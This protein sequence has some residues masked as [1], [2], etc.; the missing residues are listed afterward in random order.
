[1]CCLVS[2][3]PVSVVA[4]TVEV[5][6]DKHHSVSLIPCLSQTVL[7][8]SIV[9]NSLYIHIVKSLAIDGSWHVADT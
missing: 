4:V 1:M 5:F 2:L 7:Q 8:R 9:P 3:S 6:L